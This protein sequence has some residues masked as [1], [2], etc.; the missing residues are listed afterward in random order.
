MPLPSPLYVVFCNLC[1][2]YSENS[3]HAVHLCNNTDKWIPD[4]NPLFAGFVIKTKVCKAGA[5]V[6]KVDKYRKV[7]LP[8]IEFCSVVKVNTFKMAFNAGMGA[9]NVNP[10]DDGNMLTEICHV[11]ND[12]DHAANHAAAAVVAA[13]AVADA[14]VSTEAEAITNDN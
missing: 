11:L 8:L 1:S 2:F 9:L 10:P 7:F 4:M 6:R 5:T 14:P 3:H 13:P 12:A